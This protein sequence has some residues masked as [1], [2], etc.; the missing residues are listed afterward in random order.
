MIS[1]GARVATIL[2]LQLDDIVITNK[3]DNVKLRNI[4]GVVTLKETKTETNV[5]GY[6]ID[7]KT[8]SIIE[9]L[10]LT[11]KKSEKLFTISYETA[12]RFFKSKIFDKLF[13]DKLDKSSNDYAYKKKSLHCIRHTFGTLLVYEKVNI[14]TIMSLMGH[15]RITTTEKYLKTDKKVENDSIIDL[16]SYINGTIETHTKFLKIKE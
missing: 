16:M 9:D 4:Q 7:K 10:K 6:I 5:T 1:T 13:N 2:N 14:K 12:Q 8:I 15:K 3:A 11:R